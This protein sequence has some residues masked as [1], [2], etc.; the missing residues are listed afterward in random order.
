MSGAVLN[1]ALTYGNAALSAPRSNLTFFY[2]EIVKK[3][4][5]HFVNG[6]LRNAPVSGCL[7]SPFGISIIPFSGGNVKSFLCEICVKKGAALAAPP[8]P[9]HGGVGGQF[10]RTH[11]G[12][13]LVADG[14]V[15]GV[16]DVECHV[17]V[18]PLFDD[19]IITQCA[20]FVKSFVC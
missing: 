20:Y 5:A 17:G 14:A 11:E 4:A 12:D 2:H 15:I 6:A 13:A 3:G 1:R 8:P 19:I 7:P 10:R 9:F 16:L 18:L